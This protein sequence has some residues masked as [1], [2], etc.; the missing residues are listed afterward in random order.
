MYRTVTYYSYIGRTYLL[1]QYRRPGRR[2]RNNEGKIISKMISSLGLKYLVLTV[3][4]KS[5][6]T[7]SFDSPNDISASIVGLDD[8]L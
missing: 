1:T 3:L 5:K 2:G 6:R 8:F 7:K 4:P